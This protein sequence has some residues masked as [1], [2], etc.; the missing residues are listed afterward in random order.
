[1][2]FKLRSTDGAL[3]T[4]EVLGVGVGERRPPGRESPA[5][6]PSSHLGAV[7]LHKIPP[8]ERVPF[9]QVRCLGIFTVEGPSH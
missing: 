2:V 6:T 3:G 7:L 5:S 8:E 9:L 1:M 4:A